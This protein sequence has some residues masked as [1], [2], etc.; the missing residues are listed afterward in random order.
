MALSPG[1]L[2]SC[3]KHDSFTQEISF[4]G[5]ASVT[6]LLRFFFFLT[7]QRYYLSFNEFIDKITYGCKTCLILLLKYHF[8]DYHK[9]QILIITISMVASEKKIN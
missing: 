1:D 5:L 4:L 9:L 2:N 8:E 6:H 3:L 7:Y